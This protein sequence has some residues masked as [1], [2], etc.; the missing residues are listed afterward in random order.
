MPA[1]KGSQPC[2]SRA[3]LFDLRPPDARNRRRQL[4]RIGAQQR[5][6]APVG[7][8]AHLSSCAGIER[9][10]AFA[11]QRA[12]QVALHLVKQ[13]AT[14]ERVHLIQRRRRFARTQTE[15]PVQRKTVG[16]G[17]ELLKRRGR[18]SALGQSV[19]RQAAWAQ[20]ARPRRPLADSPNAGSEPATN[21]ESAGLTDYQI[22]AGRPVCSDR[23]RLH[24]PERHQ[25]VLGVVD[26]GREIFGRR[27]IEPHRRG[28]SRLCLK[29]LELGQVSIRRAD[30]LQRVE[31]WHAR[32]RLRQ[33]DTRIRKDR[34]LL[35]RRA[36]CAAAIAPAHGAVCWC[37]GRGE[38]ANDSCRA[39]ADLQR[40]W[41]ETC[42]RRVQEE[43][44][45]RTSG[46][47]L[48]RSS[49]QRLSRSGARAARDA[50]S[51]AAR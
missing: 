27:T 50:A 20:T 40:P 14:C 49:R 4:V 21:A 31:R 43:I 22:I 44:R 25:I 12:K 36:R 8:R 3:D 19:G 30:D 16:A 9:Q 24:F 1:T 32:P 46:R 6:R 18:V 38:T 41:R 2:R 33:I 29:L 10:H 35:R 23:R 42:L 34:S 11:A 37:S 5:G 48:P 39:A 7:D 17:G 13:R 15:D 51:A 28:S 47:A 26:R 45:L